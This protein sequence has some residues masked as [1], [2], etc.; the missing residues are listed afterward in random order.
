[1]TFMTVNNMSSRQTHFKS[2]IKIISMSMHIGKILNLRTS[3][4]I[5]KGSK[6]YSF[7]FARIRKPQ[8]LFRN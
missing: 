4:W 5:L 3:L 1:M 2:L 8:D 7:L 6:K